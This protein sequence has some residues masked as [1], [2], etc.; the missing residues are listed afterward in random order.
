MSEAVA[1]KWQNDKV[2]DSNPLERPDF[3]PLSEGDLRQLSRLNPA[4]TLGHIALEW[5]AIAAAIDAQR[6]WGH[7][8]L[9]PAAVMFLGARQMGLLVLMH[10]G[11]HFRLHPKKE[12]ND[13]LADLLCAWPVFQSTRHYRTL[14]HFAHHRDAGTSADAHIDQIY[15]AEGDDW[16]FPKAPGG[17]ARFL[18]RPL[19]GGDVLKLMTGFRLSFG[20]YTRLAAVSRLCYY[21]LGLAGI[22]YFQLGGVFLFYWVIPW[23]TWLPAILRLKLMAEHFGMGEAAD[24]PGRYT[25]TTV[26]SWW[27]KVFIMPHNLNYHIEHHLYPSVPF[28]RLPQLHRALLARPGA[29]ARMRVA[30]G[31]MEVLREL[32]RPLRAR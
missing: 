4:V 27:E 10:E 16:V 21:A 28:F 19:L 7:P 9:Y 17:L 14:R 18:L 29:R 3:D 8:L 11:V 24:R 12:W 32:T 20:A 2:E 5:A 6:R 1:L 23:C 30:H 25:R 13:W 26:L 22:F 15:S 31:Y